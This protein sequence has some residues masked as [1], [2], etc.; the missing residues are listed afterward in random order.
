MLGSTINNKLDAIEEDV[1]VL[2]LA[3][4]QQTEQFRMLVEMNRKLIEILTP[5]QKDNSGQSMATS[6]ARLADEVERQ[7]R[8]MEE[9]NEVI[10]RYI[11]DMPSMVT[12]SVLEGTGGLL[13]AIRDLPGKVMTAVRDVL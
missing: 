10:V 4:R 13:A 5:A 6:L 1:C 8:G 12:R 11:R 2:A 9:L 3:I 7:N